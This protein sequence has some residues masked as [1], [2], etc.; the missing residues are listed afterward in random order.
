MLLR[1][2]QRFLARCWLLPSLTQHGHIPHS[3]WQ[4]QSRA[5]PRP[6]PLALV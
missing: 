6:W 5:F 3:T 2:T 1:H 4:P